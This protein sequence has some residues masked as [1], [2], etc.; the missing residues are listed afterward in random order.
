M[1]KQGSRPFGSTAMV[2][3]SRPFGGDSIGATTYCGPHHS[4]NDF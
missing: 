1:P 2:F 4:G 3:G